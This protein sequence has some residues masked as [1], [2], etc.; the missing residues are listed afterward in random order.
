MTIPNT[1]PAGLAI[2]QL[3]MAALHMK[4]VTDQI[5]AVDNDPVSGALV[6]WAMDQLLA[7]QRDIA[8][9]IGE[10]RKEAT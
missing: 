3:E 10:M 6:K 5:G 9:A 1:W 8:R 7:G 2:T 4:I